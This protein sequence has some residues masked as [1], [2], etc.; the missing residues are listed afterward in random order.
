MN[1]SARKVS[2]GF[3]LLLVA[4]LG[5]TAAAPALAAKPA[6]SLDIVPADAAFYSAMLRNREQFEKIVNSKAFAKLKALP[7]VQMGLGLYQ[8][9][10]ADPSSPVGQ[11][12]AARRDPKLKKALNFLADLLSDEIFVYGGPSINQTIDLLQG[13][14]NDAQYASVAR[15]I[16]EA[17]EGAKKPHAKEFGDREVAQAFI[18]RINLLKFPE[19]VIGFKVKDKAVAKE[20][21]DELDTNLQLALAQAPMLQDRLKRVTISGHSYL[22]F[23]LDGSLIPWKAEEIE[24]IRSLAATP[25]DGDKLIEHLK[26]LTLVVSL[27]L[28]D[29]YLLLAVGPSTDVLAK[30]GKGASLRSLPELA[31]VAQFADQ[32]ICS[33]SYLSKTLN[34]HFNTTKSGIDNLLQKVK[35]FLPSL[36]IPDKARA[37]IVK[38][39]AVMAADLKTLVPE[40]GATASVGFLTPSGVENYDYDWSE[41]PEMD[42]SKPLDLLRHVGGNP[43]A[44]WVGRS[45]ASP[46]GYDLLVKW[47]GIGYRYFE[48]Y[49]LAAMKAEERAKF[50]KVFVQVKPLLGRLDKTTRDLLI[51]A[52]ADGQTGLVLDAKLSSQQFIKALP[53]TNQALTMIE[54][55]IVVGVS[56]ANKLK[57]AFGEYYAVADDFVEVLKGIDGSGIPKA[58]KIPRPRIYKLRLG[59]A[60][61]YPLPAEWGVDTRVLPNAA[62]SEKVAVL[63]I[64]GK[65]SIRLLEE[66]EPKIADIA[67]PTDRPLASVGGLDF[68]ALIDALDPWVELALEKGTEQLSPDT[69]E[70]ARLHAKTVMEVLK[71]Y[72]GSVWETYMEGKAAVT[73]SRSEY[74]DIEE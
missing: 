60:Y 15:G 29:D 27:G 32:R 63:A 61:G 56:D 31:A 19:L 33:V 49:G 42:C 5:L 10:A 74:H 35:S 72:R 13:F 48:E 67:L 3:A 1:F 25:A 57:Q 41:Q 22:T 17:Q 43:I 2:L 18:K 51:P 71:V 20:L 45:K 68:A 50:E 73:H 62:V 54:P 8:M 28:H 44:V 34:E 11:F 21:L 16:R 64:S 65:H 58:F 23:K 24:K 70:S 53:R 39:S 30:I 59:M 7:Y 66:K 52:L 14:I 12:E 69:A 9:Q 55:A 46:E 37:E 47:M 4:L 38:D 40:V 36:P 6:A 26:K